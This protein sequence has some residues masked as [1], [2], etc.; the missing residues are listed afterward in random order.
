MK[1]LYKLPILAAGLLAAGGLRAS[2]EAPFT[3]ELRT[4]G[5]LAKPV[6]MGTRD[7]IGQTS[8]VVA[9]GG[10]RTLVATFLNLRAFSFFEDKRWDDLAETY[11]LIVDLAPNTIY[12]WDSGGWNLAYNAASYYRFDSELPALRRREGWRE[13]ILRGRAFYERGAKMNPDDWKI[14]AALGRLLSDCNKLVDFPAAA[15]AFKA[16]ADT[17]RAPSYVRRSQLFAMART[18]GLEAESLDLARRL[19]MDPSNRVATLSCLLLALEC[20]AAPDR[21]PLKV[22][23]AIFESDAAA[24]DQ[25]SDYWVRV[26]ERFPLE[27]VATA[28]Q[29]LE[30]QL[31]IPAEKS[32]FRRAL[33]PMESPDDWF[34]TR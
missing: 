11:D 31:A 33:Q 25:L 34:R 32:V 27:G 5:L 18:P 22:A 30:K 26:R 15:A 2:W 9:L 20:R 16:S 13:S 6:E 21:P 17:G 29:E 23:R 14:N 8:S 7:K 28:L 24:H 3:A 1:R 12:Y 4:A 10:L 19:Y